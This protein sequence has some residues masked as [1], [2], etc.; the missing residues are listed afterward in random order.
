MAELFMVT[1]R[2]EYPNT[3]PG[4]MVKRRGRQQR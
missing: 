2:F 1:H 4:I 3:G